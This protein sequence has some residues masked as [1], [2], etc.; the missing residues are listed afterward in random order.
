MNTLII[1]QNP[2]IAERLN[3]ILKDGSRAV[4]YGSSLVGSRYDDLLIIDWPLPGAVAREQVIEWFQSAVLTCLTP[5]GMD[6]WRNWV[7]PALRGTQAECLVG[8]VNGS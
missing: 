4:T 2:Y 1:V 8:R 5:E 7:G 3:R 6:R